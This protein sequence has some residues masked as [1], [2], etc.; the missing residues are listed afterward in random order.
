MYILI[1]YYV[2]IIFIIITIINCIMI[3]YR[4]LTNDLMVGT[5]PSSLDKLNK[6]VTL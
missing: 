2:N 1:N 4:E 6:L 5:I 3:Y